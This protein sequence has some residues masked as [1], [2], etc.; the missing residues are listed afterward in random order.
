MKRAITSR[1]LEDMKRKIVLISGP[2]QAGKTT[3]SK[4]L[5]SEFDYFNYD[6]P[7]HRLM[8]KSKTWDRKKP[9]IIFDEL[10]KMDQWKLFLKGTYDTEGIPPALVVTGSAR[11]DAFRKVGD[12]LAGRYFSHR[13]HPLDIKEASS[14]LEPKEAMER[15]LKVGGFPEPF[16]ENDSRFYD[17]WKKTHLDV[18]LRQDLI[19]LTAITDIQSIETLIELLR[20]RVGSP[21]SYASLAGDLQK[22]AKT[23][24]SWLLLLENLYV[25]FPVRPWHRNITRSILKE[26]KYYFYDTGQLAE[27]EGM[28]LENLTACSL[29]K[30]AHSLEDGAG[31]RCDLCYFRTKDG[32]E[33]DFVLSLDDRITA[34]YEVKRSG[35]DLS[36]GFRHFS[37]H[38]KEAVKVQLVA[39]PD[40]EKTFP[41]GEEV[42]NLAG[43][44][45]DL[46]LE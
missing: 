3:L 28:R 16:L 22:D 20:Y 17:R 34:A 7:S 23:V 10:H 11:M 5:S 38:L 13:L 33:L 36:S 44:L 19:D 8:L 46:N 41:G 12:S 42:R 45:A 37:P 39:Y 35:T 43:Y 18:I 14:F 2:R 27:D 24:K 29:L 9:L 21:V 4:M 30:Y 26:P 1:I 6:E 32:K 31:K 15:I 25:I 40:R